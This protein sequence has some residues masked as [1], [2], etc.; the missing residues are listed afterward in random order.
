MK[1]K[2]IYYFSDESDQEK[3]ANPKCLTPSSGRRSDRQLD[4][5]NQLEKLKTLEMER[6]D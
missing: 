4:N 5:P 3:D 1:K 6:W 2:K